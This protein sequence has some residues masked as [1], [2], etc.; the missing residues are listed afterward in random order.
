MNHLKYI[1]FF[2]AVV[3]TSG[4]EKVVDVELDQAAPKLVIDASLQWIK[5]TSGNE[6]TIRLSQT[7]GYFDSEI[8]AVTG[9][10]VIV[11]DNLG[12]V[13]D[14]V[15]AA[16]GTYTCVDFNPAIN[17]QY[18]LQVITS[19]QTYV[20]TES[21]LA[22]P[23]IEEIVQNNDGGFTGDNIEIRAFYTDNANTDDYY[24]TRFKA[25][26]AS[27]PEYEVTEDRFFQG[28]RIFASYSDSDLEPGDVLDLTISG[29]SQRYYNYMNILISIAGSNGGS[30]FQSPPATVR[31]NIV[32][33][34]NSTDYPLGYFSVSEADY[35]QVIIN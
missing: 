8:P 1:V 29:I 27:I 23:E 32:N 19:G 20:A 3:L 4:C 18:T 11:T 16:P 10:S 12:N 28:N 26:F 25:D 33:T 24:L 14:F 35:R 31:G 22:V 9:A 13:F 30:P 5:G 15:E 7:T 21:M 2:V 17:A 34:T 6:Q